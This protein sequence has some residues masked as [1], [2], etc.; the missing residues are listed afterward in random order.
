MCYTSWNDAFVSCSG[1][2]V[3][4][5]IF[6]LR[7]HLNWNVH[8]FLRRE[9][10]GC[11]R[12]RDHSHLSLFTLSRTFAVHSWKHWC[13]YRRNQAGCSRRWFTAAVL[14]FFRSV[15]QRCFRPWSP[16]SH[17]EVRWSR[18]SPPPSW[19]HCPSHALCFCCFSTFFYCKLSTWILYFFF[20]FYTIKIRKLYS[21]VCFNSNV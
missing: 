21:L 14:V 10:I 8:L 2:S 16:S 18:Y 6:H 12:W 7:K 4:L 5:F 9:A 17:G 13:S 19:P 15:H 11:G 20:L 1:Q 3:H